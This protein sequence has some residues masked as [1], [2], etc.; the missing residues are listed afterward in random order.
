MPRLYTP[1]HVAHADAL[2][3]DTARVARLIVTRREEDPRTNDALAA[4]INL[5]KGNVISM[6]K[7]IAYG[8]PGKPLSPD[9]LLFLAKEV[10]LGSFEPEIGLMLL[11]EAD[12]TL[13]LRNAMTNLMGDSDPHLAPRLDAIRAWADQIVVVPP[14]SAP[15]V[16]ADIE[17]RRRAAKDTFDEWWLVEDTLRDIWEAR[18]E[19]GEKVNPFG[20]EGHADRA[21][22]EDYVASL[23]T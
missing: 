15:D 16:A 23:A 19:R 2:F 5:G 4:A 1:P 8:E 9:N 10:G 13:R 3:T 7:D 22:A 6:L 21:M 12:R 11:G 17:A 14:G 18:E 20:E